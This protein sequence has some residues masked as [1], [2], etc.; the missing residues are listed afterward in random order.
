VIVTIHENTHH[1]HAK[2]NSC[3]WLIVFD[4]PQPVDNHLTITANMTDNDEQATK[5]NRTGIDHFT[6][7]ESSL[8]QRRLL[9]GLDRLALWGEL[10]GVESADASLRADATV[11]ATTTL[12]HVA[13]ELRAQD[14]NTAR[15]EPND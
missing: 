8:S 12:G 11:S 3:T 9:W 13:R 1:E 6:R 7:D 15:G 5:Q 10:D 14:A 4:N 2:T